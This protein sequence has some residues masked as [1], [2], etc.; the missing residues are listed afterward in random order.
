MRSRSG[1]LMGSCANLVVV[2]DSSL[3][4]SPLEPAALARVAGAA[5][6]VTLLAT[7]TSTNAV[8]VARPVAGQVV[9]AEHQTAGRGRLD[10][11]WVAPVGASLA[12]SAVVD[13]GLPDARWP[14][15]PLAAGL[16]VA[17]A[18]RRAGARPTLKWPNDV[19]IG[20]RKLA[21]ILVERVGD[22][23]RAVI[24]IGVNVDLSE[25][26]LPVPVATSL[27]LE[28]VS[29]DRT[30]LFGW[31]LAAL[32]TRLGALRMDAVAFVGAYRDACGTVGREV[33]VH[34]P[35]GSTLVGTGRSVDDR[36]R[37]VVWTVG[38]EVA[39]GA[40]D[41]VHVRDPR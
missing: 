37:L 31:I 39:I 18:V 41:V 9:V 4:R 29:V 12:F 13:P 32:S 40:G 1:L 24:G 33:E 19:L 14:L 27:A 25:D 3:R 26:E 30:D 6:S 35:D 20:E 22:P 11:S 38:R 16:A 36:G 7:A 10:R 8:A 34:L 5:W 28:G 17:D 15:V 23:A 2:S 21:G